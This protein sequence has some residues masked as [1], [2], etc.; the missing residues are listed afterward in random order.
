MR[1]SGILKR[2]AVGAALAIAAVPAL[3][4]VSS[5]SVG[6]IAAPDSPAA[7]A[8]TSSNRA[9]GVSWTE[10]S[11]GTI[12]FKATA[13]ATGKATKSCVTHRLA[14]SITSLVNGVVYDVSVTAR[15]AGG[16]SAPSTPVS[17]IVGVPGP[18]LSVHTTA[19]I[20]SATIK[21]A[22][23][24]ASGVTH[25]TGY[26]ATAAPGGFSCSTSGTTPA[27]T[28]V[29]S[30]LTTGTTYTVTVTATNAYGTGAPSKAA[31]VTAK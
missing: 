30:G 23:S 10:S 20:A 14:C 3:A 28:C 18:P 27:Q 11:T 4:S 15:N 21:W 1:V 22:K 13:T 31:T 24:K 16:T 9:L 29:I 2:G 5:A 26:M 25:T 8:L 7:V 17:Q 12:T 6:H 19:G